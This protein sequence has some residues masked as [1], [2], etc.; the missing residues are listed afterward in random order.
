MDPSYW[1]GKWQAGDTLFHRE[2]PH[3][4]LVKHFPSGGKGRVMVPLCGKSGDMLWLRG[5]G[6]EVVGIE[7]SPIACEAFFT[8]NKIPCAKKTVGE[9]T[10]Y[11]G[12]GIV[13]WCG[14]FFAAP[15]EAWA[16]CTHLYDR[17]ALV[18][19]PPELRR[20]YASTITER[21]RGHEILLISMS[22]EGSET[23]GPPFSVPEKEVRSLYGEAFQVELLEATVD[24]AVRRADKF[25]G[26]EI[27]ESVY[28]AR[29]K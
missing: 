11:D 20:R 18:A 15:A 26:I 9:F 2:K 22:Y 28:F 1:H 19:L 4:Q 6:F 13:L 3:P 12:E 16:G 10:I 14:D 29:T 5:Q 27:T 8:D 25:Q 23:L 21:F 7:L 24:S 17:A